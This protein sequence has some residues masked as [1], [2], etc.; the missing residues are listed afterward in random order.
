MRLSGGGSGYDGD[1]S[2]PSAGESESRARTL[3]ASI[4][5]DNGSEFSSRVLEAWVMGNDVQL[6]FIRPGPAGGERIH[7]KFQ[8]AIARRVFERGMVCFARWC[9][10]KAGEVPR[11]L[12][13]R[14]AAQLTGGSN[15]GGIRG[16]A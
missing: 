1:E 12:Q 11:A 5:V 16:A 15:A 3:P 13:S 10:A 9:P 14:T 8:R 7:R 4:T 6:C 2:S